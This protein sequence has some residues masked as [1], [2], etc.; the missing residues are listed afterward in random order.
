M[1]LAL[2]CIIFHCTVFQLSIHL[3]NCIFHNSITLVQIVC[4]HVQ[5]SINKTLTC[6]INLPKSFYFIYSSYYKSIHFNYIKQIFKFETFK[7]LIAKLVKI[8]WQLVHRSFPI[9]V[10]SAWTHWSGQRTKLTTTTAL[11]CKLIIKNE[12]SQIGRIKTKHLMSAK[13]TITMKSTRKLS[14]QAIFTTSGRAIITQRQ[15]LK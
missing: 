6:P 3:I 14:C 5:F 12:F 13:T 15:W 7:K 4:I 2:D 10:H 8:F 1:Y 11:E 9:R